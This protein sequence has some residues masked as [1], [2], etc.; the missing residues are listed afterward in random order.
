MLANGSSQPINGK[1]VLHPTRSLPIPSSLHVSDFSFN[2]CSLSQLTKALNF[3]VTFS[4]TCVFQDLQTKMMKGLGHEKGGLYYLTIDSTSLVSS[5]ML[6]A[7]I[8]LLLIGIFSRAILM[9]PSLS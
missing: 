9:W 2:L 4:P 1:D 8:S 3:S 7:T 5:S 6:S